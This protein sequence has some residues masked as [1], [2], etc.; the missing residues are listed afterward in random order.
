MKSLPCPLH[1]PLLVAL[2]LAACSPAQEVPDDSGIASASTATG[3]TSGAGGDVGLTTSDPGGPEACDGLDN[4]G[5]GAVDEGCD[6]APGAKQACFPGPA[7]LAGTGICTAGTQTCEGTD[8]ELGTGSWGACIGAVV[9]APETCGDGVDSDCSGAD[10]PCDGS[11]GGG[12]NAGG[13]GAGGDPG[14]G[15]AGGGPPDPIAVQLFLLGDCIT[16]TCPPEAP[17]PVGCDVFF[18]PGDT[19][20]CVASTPDNSTVYFQAGDQCDQGLVTGTLYCSTEMG[21]PLDQQSCPI[22]KQIK[23]YPPDPSGCPAVQ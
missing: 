10:E 17:Y 7:S 14:S 21:A 11:G 4:D 5:D 20:G 12:A 18:T 9:P 13:A 23:F 15:G 1:H 6:C 22:N 8:G 3:S 19:R 16:A 2:V